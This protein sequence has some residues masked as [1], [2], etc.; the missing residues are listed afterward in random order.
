[1]KALF[2]GE[3]RDRNTILLSTMRCRLSA[4]SFVLAVGCWSV[5]QSVMVDDGSED[6]NV[7]FIISVSVFRHS[8]ATNCGD[9]KR[10]F[11]LLCGP[12]RYRKFSAIYVDASVKRR[13][14]HKNI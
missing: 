9:S 13:V 6:R 12:A 3:V 4:D 1:M 10:G 14:T 8:V 5:M 2:S 11:G 7:T